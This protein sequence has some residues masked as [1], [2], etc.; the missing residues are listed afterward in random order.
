M[1]DAILLKDGKHEG[2][3]KSIMDYVANKFGKL[4]GKCWI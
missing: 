1:E 3:I 2:C 4:M